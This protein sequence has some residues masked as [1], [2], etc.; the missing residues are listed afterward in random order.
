MIQPGIVGLYIPGSQ[1]AT[2]CLGEREI[3]TAFV[4]PGMGPSLSR[5]TGV[6]VTCTEGRWVIGDLT[7]DDAPAGHGSGLG[8]G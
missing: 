6:V 2:V 3:I 4:P 1:S 7:P 5:G 8:D